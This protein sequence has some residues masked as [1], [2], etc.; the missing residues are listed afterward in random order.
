MFK[1]AKIQLNKSKPNLKTKNPWKTI[2]KAQQIKPTSIKGTLT[3]KIHKTNMY[4]TIIPH[5]NLRFPL[6]FSQNKPHQS[7]IQITFTHPQPEA[8]KQ[9][10]YQRKP[11][12]TCI[13]LR[14]TSQKQALP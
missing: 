6:N 2:K 7:I 3:P 13:P 10:G 14:A 8:I 1:I 5:H 12:R 4:K 9:C 11:D